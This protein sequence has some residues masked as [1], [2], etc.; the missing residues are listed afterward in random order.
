MAQTAIKCFFASTAQALQ[1][2][3]FPRNALI[4]L[5]A[6]QRHSLASHLRKGMRASFGAGGTLAVSA[7]FAMPQTRRWM[8]ADGALQTAAGFWLGVMVIGEIIFAGS[9]ALFYGMTALRGDLHAWSKHLAHGYIPGD[10]AGNAAL[11]F[12]LA[13]AVLITLS[14]AAQL[15]PAI[16]RRAPRLH[17]WN[18]RVFILSA[19]GLALAG[20][21]LLIARGSPISPVQQFGTVLLGVLML[22]CA[23][24]AWRTALRRDFVAHRRWALRLF[25]LASSAL[26]IRAIVALVSAVLAGVGKLDVTV[27]QGPV[28]TAAIFGQ[29]CVPLT[30]LE[31][32]FLSQTRGGAAARLSMAA[33][34]VA[35]TLALGAGVG[36]ASAAIFVPNIKSAL[37]KRP[38]IAMTLAEVIKSDGVEAAVKQYRALRAVRPV[39][40]NFDE[41]ELN[42][43]GYDLLHAK[44]TGDAV[45]ILQLNTEAYPASANTWDSLGEAYMDDG[46]TSDAIANYRKSLALN[47][48][49]KNAVMMLGKLGAK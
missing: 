34:L 31:C 19:I 18:G 32:Y 36:V 49:N 17:R 45:R 43:L 2:V 42:A 9:T 11:I 25:L 29:Y 6:V 38:S 14:G 47:P 40:M 3:I 44:H 16:R 28:A 37:D 26:F 27:I 33:V 35:F 15:I 20:L 21:Y 23:T 48:A 8:S 39:T 24:M 1:H 22:V 12:H 13:A 46:D 41:D 5:P 4:L 30:V 10:A 7:S